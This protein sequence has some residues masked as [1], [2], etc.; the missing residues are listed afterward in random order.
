M[1]A[2]YLGVARFLKPHGLKGEAVVFPLTD[3]PQEVFVKGRVL[4]PVDDD[5][6]P[7]GEELVINHARP[8]QRRWLLLFEGI[9]DR[10][11]LETWPQF[12]L[13]ARSN[14]LKP[15]DDGE[16][17]FHEIPGA[18]IVQDGVQI[19]T[20]KEI[21]SVPGGRMLVMERDGRDHLIPF[22][23]PIVARLDREAR[24]I[25]VALPSGLLEI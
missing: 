5:G 3:E 11:V 24:R 13:G 9:S 19:G 23:A 12:M 6:I 14:E 2:V 15:P 17:Y 7:L 21:L 1:E 8:F 4:V 10:T 16:M 20:A 22:R 18:A 25:E